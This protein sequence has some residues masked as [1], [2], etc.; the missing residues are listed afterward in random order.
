MA[1]RHDRLRREAQRAR[2]HHDV[3]AADPEPFDR[4]KAISHWQQKLATMTG[5]GFAAPPFAGLVFGGSD[6][7]ENGSSRR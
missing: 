3:H 6:P 2:E 4:E 1:R 7:I 5:R